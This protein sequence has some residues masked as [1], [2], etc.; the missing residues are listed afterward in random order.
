[1]VEGDREV[2]RMFCALLDSLFIMVTLKGPAA[3]LGIFVAETSERQ[4][5]LHVLE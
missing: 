5:L 4:L 1:M 3:E 2:L